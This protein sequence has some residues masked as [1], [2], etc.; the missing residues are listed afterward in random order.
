[1]ETTET[2]ADLTLLTAMKRFGTEQSARDFL[3]SVRW[4][5]G[6]Y[7]PHC[8]NGDLARIHRIAENKEAGVRAGLLR[9][10]ECGKQFTVTVGTIFEDSHIPL[11]KWMIAFFRMCSSKTQV[12]ALQLKRELEIGS[13]RTALFMC[14]RIREAMKEDLGRMLT[15]TVTVDEAYVGGR[16]RGKGAGF[17]PDK[18]PVVTMMEQG[19]IARSVVVP[20]VSRA[21]LDN[22]LVNN[23]SPTAEIQTDQLDHYKSIGKMFSAHE[24]VN[25]SKK[26]WVIR[27]AKGQKV[28]TNVCES[29]F[30]NM[31]RSIDG[32]HHFVSRKYLP[33]YVAEFDLKYN[34][35]KMTDGERTVI[36]LRMVDGKRLM[37]SK[38][39]K[40]AKKESK[41]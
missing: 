28:S 5:N 12:S 40:R 7:C 25:H 31:K 19:G 37:R 34:T 15:G 8:G 21:V 24:T 35:R 9:C 20:T 1:M 32:T 36:A 2:G 38:S 41:A 22:V 17:N 30:S 10:N 4:P 6:P 18:T 39:V 33:L 23:I 3:E 11:N 26:Q 16:R 14:H 13:Y 29:F 27:G